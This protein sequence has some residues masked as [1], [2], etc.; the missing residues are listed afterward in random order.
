VTFFSGRIA[1]GGALMSP[2][3][4]LAKRLQR[5]ILRES[6]E[7]TDRCGSSIAADEKAMTYRIE[8]AWRNEIDRIVEL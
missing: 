5:F 3:Q 6:W 8:L 1:D 2:E 7:S 4:I